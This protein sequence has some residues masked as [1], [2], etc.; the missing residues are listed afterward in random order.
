M[1]RKLIP[2]IWVERAGALLRLKPSRLIHLGLL[3]FSAT[4]FLL[5]SSTPLNAV[6]NWACFIEKRKKINFFSFYTFC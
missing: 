6:L 2:Y 3:L 5:Y 1:D 4:P